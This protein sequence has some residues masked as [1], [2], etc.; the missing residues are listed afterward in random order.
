MFPLILT[1]LGRAYNRG[2]YNPHEGAVSTRGNIPKYGCLE[3]PGRLET[4]YKMSCVIGGL[5]EEAQKKH[6]LPYKGNIGI[7][8]SN[9]LRSF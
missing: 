5:A 8:I 1:V 7:L 4:A 2:Y 6:I 3:R 9:F